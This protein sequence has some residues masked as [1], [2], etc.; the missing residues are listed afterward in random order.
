MNYVQVPNESY[1][2]INNYKEKY[3]EQKNLFDEIEGNLTQRLWHQL[4]DNLLLLSSLPDLQKGNA[5]IEIYNGLIIFIESVFNPMK[6]LSLVKNLLTNFRGKMEEGLQFVENL[7]K[8]LKLKGEEI[9]Y[10]KIIKG[11]CFFELGRKY[12]LEDLMKAVEGEFEN[13]SEIDPLVYSNFYKL[14]T[15][16]YDQQKKYDEFYTSAFQYLAYE[17]NISNEEKLNLCFNMCVASLIG[18]KMF[19]FAELIEKDFFKLMLGTQYD[20]I[21][22]LIL[23]FNSAKVDQFLS[24]IN[25]YSTQIN[26]NAVLKDKVEFL[27]GKIRIAALLDLVFQKNKNERTVTYKEI[28]E[29]CKVENDQIEYILM[30]ALSL[31]LI[32]G[33]IDEVEQKIIVNWIQ[34]KYLDKEKIAFLEKR[35]ENWIDKAGKMLT[36]FEELGSPLLN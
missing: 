8:K 15:Y 32:K 34:P 18:E 16:Y 4:A 24:M 3:P 12:D 19:N 27:K 33:N 2:L 10:I 20:W 9:L 22:N 1:K 35:F 23:S 7:E 13:K 30:K 14:A 25:T 17:K 28:Q 29:N 26:G 36:N 5:L 11:Y 31:G 6:L 21:Y